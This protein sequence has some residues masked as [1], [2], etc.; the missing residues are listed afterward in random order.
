MAR[1]IEYGIG[2]LACHTEDR[3]RIVARTA[4]H[5]IGVLGDILLLRRHR[6]VGL[7]TFRAQA[8]V[9]PSTFLSDFLNSVR[10]H[11]V[12]LRLTVNLETIR[13]RCCRIPGANRPG[14]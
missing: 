8:F 9:G 13:A 11:G 12:P 10:A 6:L 1:S 5:G 14:R 2:V 7:F 4:D 3:I